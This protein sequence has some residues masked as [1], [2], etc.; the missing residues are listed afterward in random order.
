MTKQMH[1]RLVVWVRP[2]PPRVG[3]FWGFCA[4]RIL[5]VGHKQ[6]WDPQDPPPTRVA[7]KPAQ[8]ERSPRSF[9][10]V[11]PIASAA[12]QSVGAVDRCTGGPRPVF[13][14]VS[15]ST[16][17]A[18]CPAWG[19]LDSSPQKKSF[20][21]LFQRRRGGRAGQVTWPEQRGVSLGFAPGGHSPASSAQ[22]VSPVPLSLP[23]A[24]GPS[25][26]VTSLGERNF[27]L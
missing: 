18:P 10:K 19:E 9:P 25:P 2:Q 27:F 3:G 11:L 26:A 7:R 20:W 6:E 22:V 8:S 14:P 24:S 15:G 21:S 12:T 4:H 17:S 1:P 23:S 16:R 5:A 13:P